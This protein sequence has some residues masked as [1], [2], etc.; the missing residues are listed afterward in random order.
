MLEKDN[1]ASMCMLVVFYE[2]MMTLWN[3]V[4]EVSTHIML[5]AGFDYHGY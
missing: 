5:D 3:Q 2:G 4:S 1:W